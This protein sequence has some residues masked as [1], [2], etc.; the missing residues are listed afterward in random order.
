[1][2]HYPPNANVDPVFL[3]IGI[4]ICLLIIAWFARQEM[5]AKRKKKQLELSNQTVDN[6]E[7]IAFAIACQ[8]RRC[9]T[10]EDF[11]EAVRAIGRYEWEFAENDNAQREAK[12]LKEILDVKAKEVFGVEPI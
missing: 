1:M 8:I 7:T 2:I 9:R 11:N 3:G 5:N 6:V 10:P 12:I 4:S